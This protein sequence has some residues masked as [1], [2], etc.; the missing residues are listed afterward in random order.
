MSDMGW[1]AVIAGGR[2][3]SPMLHTRNFADTI[4]VDGLTYE[5]SVQRE[6]QWCTADGWRGLVLSIQLEGEQREALLE[7]PT[8]K[9]GNGSPH[10]RRPKINKTVVANGVRAALAAGW[11]PRSRGRAETYMVDANDC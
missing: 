4:E 8:P 5:W 3:N 10:R 2:Q 11:V 9:S 7:F 6:P 1:I